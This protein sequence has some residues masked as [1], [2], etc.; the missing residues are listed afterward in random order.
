MDS[1]MYASMVEDAAPASDPV[2]AAPVEEDQDVFVSGGDPAAMSLLGRRPMPLAKALGAGVGLGAG[3]IAGGHVVDSFEGIY[4]RPQNLQLR[5][6]HAV[7]AHHTCPY[8]AGRMEFESLCSSVMCTMS[9]P[10]P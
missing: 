2:A 4:V 1:D 8:V 7:F 10:P 6:S 3:L 5:A 9:P